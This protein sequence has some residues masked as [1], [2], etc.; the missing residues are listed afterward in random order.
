MMLASFAGVVM[1]NLKQLEAI[2]METMKELKTFTCTIKINFNNNQIKAHN[3]EQYLEILKDQFLDDYGIFLQDD[4][5]YNLT[6]K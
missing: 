6:V 5:I 2:Q 1:D 3:K 4:E